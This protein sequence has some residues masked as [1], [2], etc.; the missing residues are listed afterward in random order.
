SLPPSATHYRVRNRLR[1]PAKLESMK[2][3]V[4]LLLLSFSALAEVRTM[5]LRQALDTAM[6]QSPDVLLA[7]LDQQK[8]RAEVTVAR[9]PFSPKVFGGSGLA[10]GSG[11]PQS[12]EGSAPSAFRADTKWALFNRPQSFIAAQANEALRASEIDISIKQEDVAYR[13]A[14][15]F[16]DA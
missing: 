14:A 6:A 16:L 2:A 1:L 7:R 11:F 8:A 3:P 5:T 4:L 13:V 15:L 10:K 9:D 12:I